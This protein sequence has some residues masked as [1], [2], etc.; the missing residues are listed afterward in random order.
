MATVKISGNVRIG[1]DNYFGA[2]SIVIPKIQIGN[3][4]RLGA[5]SVLM[6]RPKDG[7]LYLGVPAMMM[8]Y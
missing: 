3:E 6:T 1:Q 2:G 7:C 8:Q 4:V 5:G